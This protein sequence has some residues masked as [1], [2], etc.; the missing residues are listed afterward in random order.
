MGRVEFLVSKVKRASLDL[1]DK[2]DSQAFL[3][4]QEAKVTTSDQF[5]LFLLF[6]IHSIFL[7]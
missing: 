2:M 7:P 3:V 5:P 6:D 1:L 4:S